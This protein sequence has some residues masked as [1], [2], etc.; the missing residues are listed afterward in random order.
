[1]IHNEP[2]LA[3]YRKLGFVQADSGAVF[4]KDSPYA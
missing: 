1:M 3:M 2:A 4:R